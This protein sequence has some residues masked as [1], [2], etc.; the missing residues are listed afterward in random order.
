M[1]PREKLNRKAVAV[2]IRI[3]IPTMNID[4]VPQLLESVEEAIAGYEEAD[5]NLSTMRPRRAIR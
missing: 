5:V 4:N 1:E 3:L 2:T